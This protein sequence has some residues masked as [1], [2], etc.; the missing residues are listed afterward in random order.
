LRVGDD[1]VAQHAATVAAQRADEYGDGLHAK[2]LVKDGQTVTHPVIPSVARDLSCNLKGPSGFAL[3]MTS[4]KI[5]P[6]LQ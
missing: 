4:A 6:S 5:T 1:P 2:S 3:G